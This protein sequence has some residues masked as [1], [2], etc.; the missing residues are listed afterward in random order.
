M[1]ARRAVLALALAGAGGCSGPPPASPAAPAPAPGATP[2]PATAPAPS[3]QH[4]VGS[5]PESA[6]RAVEPVVLE[7]PPWD[8]RLVD[9]VGRRAVVVPRLLRL[10]EAPNTITDQEA[11][12]RRN[13]FGAP[14]TAAPSRFVPD[15]YGG[16]PR[17]RVM[18]QHGLTLA[19]YGAG[20][21]G[22]Y[23]L[24]AGDASRRAFDFQHYLTPS[25]GPPGSDGWPQGL[26][27]AAVASRWL[28]VANAHYTY[29]ATTGGLNGYI[30]ALDLET[31]ELRWRSRPR[32][33][34]ARTFAVVDDALV[35]GYGF[36]AEPDA[37]FVIDRFTG[38]VLD[39]LPVRTAPEWILRR[40][41]RLFVRAYDADYVFTLR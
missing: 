21:D 31:G 3:T 41:D 27:W 12:L 40:D 18:E 4:P 16:E 17:M 11:W 19:I 25:A 39:E 32:V 23:L 24:V 22:R 15:F 14:G 10:M 1:I 26:L 35:A 34:N 13:D 20:S 5:D 37:L 38:L 9:D 33:A 2:A 8:Y 30:T 36:T 6:W 7:A 28:Y 29:A